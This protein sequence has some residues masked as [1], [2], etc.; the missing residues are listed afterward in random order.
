MR[1]IRPQVPPAPDKPL[2][3]GEPIR[4]SGR[5]KLSRSQ[6]ARRG[7]RR[8][9]KAL[10]VAR[11]QQAKAYELRAATSRRAE[12]RDLLAPVYGWFIDS[13]DTANLR[14]A[15]GLLVELT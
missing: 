10:R 3:V 9:E 6:P 13:L 14:E 15:K 8:L 2:N 11:G 4:V 1:R 5:A 7:A 12:A